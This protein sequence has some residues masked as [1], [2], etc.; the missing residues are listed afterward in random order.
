MVKVVCSAAEA[1]LTLRKCTVAV[2]VVTVAVSV[3]TVAVSVVTAVRKRPTMTTTF[4][5][6]YHPPTNG[7]VEKLTEVSCIL[8]NWQISCT[9]ATG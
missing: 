2:S 9:N 4:S 7:L 8:L 6:L 5:S 3:V 1:N